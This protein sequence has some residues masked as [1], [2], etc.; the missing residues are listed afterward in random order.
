MATTAEAGP[1]ISWGL[2]KVMAIESCS[3]RSAA[4]V[5]RIREVAPRGRGLLVEVLDA[6]ESP[7]KGDHSPKRLA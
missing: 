2:G 6:F 7:R 3:D 1:A 5:Q 4:A